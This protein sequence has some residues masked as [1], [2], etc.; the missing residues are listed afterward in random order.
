MGLALSR[1]PVRMPAGSALIAQNCWRGPLG[2]INSRPGYTRWLN[3]AMDRPVTMLTRIG[4]RIL[5]VA[6][7]VEE[8]GSASC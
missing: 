2:S 1:S 4:D 5:V 7:N 3:L 6:G 8:Q